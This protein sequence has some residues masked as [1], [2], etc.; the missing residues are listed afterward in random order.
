M[1]KMDFVLVCKL[2]DTAGCHGTAHHKFLSMINMQLL[3]DTDYFILI[4]SQ[5]EEINFKYRDKE[6]H[7]YCT[8]KKEAT[9]FYLFPTRLH[10]VTVQMTVVIF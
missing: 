3:L 6:V 8:L 1:L 2:Q 5:P 7:T 4:V 10:D 9:D